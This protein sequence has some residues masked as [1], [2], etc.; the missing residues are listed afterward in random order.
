MSICILNLTDLAFKKGI[1]QVLATGG[2]SNLGGDDFDQLIADD[3][4]KAFELDEFSPVQ[5]KN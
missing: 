1:F 2:D 3:C 4:K 5:M